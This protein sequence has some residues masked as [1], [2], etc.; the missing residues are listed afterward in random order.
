MYSSYVYIAIAV[1]EITMHEK[2]MLDAVK[3]YTSPA[4]CRHMYVT[5]TLSYIYTNLGDKGI[6]IASCIK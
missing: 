2:T 5:W 4:T 1:M 3:F 6:Y